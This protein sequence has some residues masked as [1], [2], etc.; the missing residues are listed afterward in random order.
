MSYEQ[1]ALILKEMGQKLGIAGLQFDENGNCSIRLSPKIAPILHL[2]YIPSK[3]SILFYSEIGH[4]PPANEAELFRYFLEKNLFYRNSDGAFFAIDPNTA[5]LILEQYE[6]VDS[7]SP[8]RLESVLDAFIVLGVKARRK[9]LTYIKEGIKI[10]NE[11]FDDQNK[12]LFN[13][14]FLQI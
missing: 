12:D 2:H 7:L 14:Q 6:A 5:G 4:V 10:E 13:S 11:D 1:I 3:D 9:I 8:D